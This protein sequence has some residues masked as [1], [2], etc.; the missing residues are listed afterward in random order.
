MSSRPATDAWHAVE[1][2]E[3]VARL[4]TDRERGIETAEAAR[5]LG[6]FGPNALSGGGGPTRLDIL[7]RQ[8]RDVLVWLLLVA[9]LVSG[10]LLR[11]WVDAA[12]I[13]AIVLLN[14]VLGY[15]Q[16]ARADDALAR[17]KEMAAPEAKVVRG[18][19]ERLVAAS[20]VV[21]GDLVR[22]EAGDR[23]PAD[24]RVVEAAHLEADES[25][26]TGE[27]FP[28]VKMAGSVPIDAGTADRRSMVFAGTVVST[29]RGNVLVTGTG[30]NTEVGRLAAML[31]VEEP[32]TPLQVELTRVGKRIAVLAV[33]I[34]AVIFL[35]GV[36]RDLPAETM[37]LT[38][39]ALAVA[40]IPEGLTAVVTVTLSRGVS[41][42]ARN[43][44]IVRRLPAV[45]ALGSASVICTDKTGTLTRNEIRVQ[46][47]DFADLR[48]AAQ[49]AHDVDGR[50]WRYAQVAALCNDARATANGLVGDPTEVALLMSVDPVLASVSELRRQY[51]RVDEISFDSAR[52]QMTTLHSDDGGFLL[53]SK[54]APEVIIERS[55][56]FETSHGPEPLDEQRRSS[57]M[58]VSDEFAAR[59]LRTLALAYRTIP[60]QPTDLS[61]E[62]DN[63]VLIGIVGMS[64]ELR[65]EARLAVEEAQQAGIRIVMITGDHLVTAEAVARNLNIVRPGQITMSGAE[66]RDIDADTLSD[67]VDRYAVYA[68]V[69]PIDKVKIVKAWRSRGY[70]VAMT[71]D[72]INDAPALR[73]ADIGIGMGSGTDVAKDAASIV[74]ADDNFATIITAVREGRGIFANLKKVVY[75]LLSANVSEVLVMVIGFAV[76]GS[77]GEPLLATQLLWINLVT[78]GLPALALGVDPLPDG[79]MDRPPDRRRDILGPLHQL[80]ILWQGALLAA[81]ALGALVYG[82]YLRD[83]PWEYT[84]TLTFTTLVTLQLL[85]VYNVRA[86]GTS[87]WRLGFGHNNV[88]AVGVAASLALQIAVV[89]TPI[90]Q[91]LFDT[92]AIEAVD[93][94]AISLLTVAPFV[95]IDLIKQWV[96]RNHPEWETATD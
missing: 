23:V 7:L 36:A 28:V 33:V 46:A 12:V 43:H 34:A 65:P 77:L 41:S 55:Q 62:E 20:Q 21:P 1:V 56:R 50:T 63:L 80:R 82:Y 44:A 2:A 30:M 78:D 6:R 38:A 96:L 91:S 49:D 54:G 61:Q 58:T 71:G 60:D 84:R 79:L 70:I 25:A 45:E 95:M 48:V 26:L 31:E 39:V 76:F 72:G 3:V 5:R 37:F 14:A 24:A 4:D 74:I 87:V 11:Q 18:G 40:A 85:H 57:A 42:M 9:A 67:Q 75:F 52:K 15:V 59:G 32:Q 8:F 53:C 13:G 29:G 66:L 22:L 10:L 68:R 64:D 81:G 51:P 69:D 88:L 27:S 90:G 19:E 35:L 93:W 47:L 16:E 73:S 86:Q 92:V 89:Y 17:L 83:M 94:I